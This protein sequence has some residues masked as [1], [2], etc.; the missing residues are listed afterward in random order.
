MASDFFV[1]AKE[2]PKKIDKVVNPITGRLIKKGSQTY[3]KLKKQGI[4]FK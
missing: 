4:R 3:N 2:T 1:D